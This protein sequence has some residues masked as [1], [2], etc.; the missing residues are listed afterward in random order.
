MTQRGII[1][2][3][4]FMQHALYSPDFGYYSSNLA[5]LGSKGD[6]ITAPE[7]SVLFGK[8]LAL[9]CQAILVECRDPVILEFGAGSGRLCIDLL[10]QLEILHATPVKYYILEVSGALQQ[11]QKY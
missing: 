7:L 5:K 4:E 8:T 10:Q 2:F 11:E 1:T 3:A 9:Q 6:F